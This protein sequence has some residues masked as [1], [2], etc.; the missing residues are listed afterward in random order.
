LPHQPL[1]LFRAGDV[2]PG[3]MFRLAGT[4]AGEKAHHQGHEGTQR[5]KESRFGFP[6][7]LHAQLA[8]GIKHNKKGTKD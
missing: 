3:G 5:K 8:I 2:L 1:V 6:G 7:T 4:T